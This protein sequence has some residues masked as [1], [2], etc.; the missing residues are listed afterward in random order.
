M[1]PQKAVCNILKLPLQ[2]PLQ[3]MLQDL[4]LQVINLKKVKGVCNIC[5][6]CNG[7]FQIAARGV[8]KRGKFVSVQYSFTHY[9]LFNYKS[10]RI[11]IAKTISGCLMAK[12]VIIYDEVTKS[13]KACDT[14]TNLKKGWK[15]EDVFYKRLR[16]LIDMELVKVV[17]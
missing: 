6:G 4:R 13:I 8:F 15:Y 5:N 2:L 1:E 10:D 9:L 11:A 12:K 14:M 7:F 17:L 3:G 16:E